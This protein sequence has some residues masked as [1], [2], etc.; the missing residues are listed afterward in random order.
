[1]SEVMKSKRACNI[2][3][4]IMKDNSTVIEFLLKRFF[5][6]EPLNAAIDLMNEK[7]IVETLKNHTLKLLDNGKLK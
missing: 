2:F 6:D 7:N 3:P 5:V 4:I 1:M